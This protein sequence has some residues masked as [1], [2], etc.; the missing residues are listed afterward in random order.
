MGTAPGM[1]VESGG[2]VVSETAR[3][4]H[5]AVR[6]N[7]GADAVIEGQGHGKDSADSEQDGVESA[8]EEEKGDD[9]L[10]EVDFAQACLALTLSLQTVPRLFP[11]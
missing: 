4:L 10:A 9:L 5:S 11:N 3:I 7:G 6:V 1:Q 2:K 8:E